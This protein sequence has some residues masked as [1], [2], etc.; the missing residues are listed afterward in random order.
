MFDSSWRRERCLRPIV[1]AASILAGG[2][3]ITFGPQRLAAQAGATLRFERPAAQASDT[4][5]FE[6]ASDPTVRPF[7]APGFP[8][9]ISKT[10]AIDFQGNGRPD[11]LACHGT[12]T[13]LPEAKLPCRVLRPQSDGSVTEVTRQMFGTGALP[14]M[15]SPIGLVTGDFNGDGRPDVF[16]A[17]SGYDAAPFRG[18]TNVLLLSKTDGSYSDQSSTLPQAPAFSYFACTGDINGDGHLDIYVSTLDAPPLKVAPYLLIGNGTGA[19]TESTAGLPLPIRNFRERYV[20]CV[21]VDVDG[22]TYSDLVLGTRTGPDSVVLFNDGTGDFT[23]RARYELPPWPQHRVNDIVA[24]DMNRDGRSDLIMLT[25]NT[26]PVGPAPGSGLQVLINQGNGTFADETI[27]RLGTSSLVSGES[28][29]AHLRLADFNGDGWEDF[30]CRDGPETVPNRYWMSNGD[31]TWGPVAPGVLPPGSGLGI[32]AVDF[33]WDGRPDLLSINRT[34][35]GDI[36][37][38]SFFNRTPFPTMRLSRALLKFA[39]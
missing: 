13:N 19:F 11:L 21:L 17:A 39:R 33:D 23:R 31:G 37:Y 24:L 7:Q 35:T 12:S 10:L 27:T 1:V 8:A 32:H 34:E 16:I 25:S 9:T 15:V 29:C 14:S 36:R 18:E 3:L 30:Y 38:Q 4:P 20:A 22:D 5:G 28:Y 6:I 26:G 2:T